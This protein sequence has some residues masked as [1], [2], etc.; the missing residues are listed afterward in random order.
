ACLRRF[1]R[2][3]L[4]YKVETKEIERWLSTI[5]SLASKNYELAVEIAECQNLIKGYGETH[6]RGMKSF[7]SIMQTLDRIRDKDNAAQT[8]STLREA[9]LADEAGEHLQQQL[10]L[11]A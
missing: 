2:T 9:A 5:T 10:K 1:R 7:T 11:I 8:V 3:T 6:A 4:R